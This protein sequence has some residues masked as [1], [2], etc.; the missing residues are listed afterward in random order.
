[1]SREPQN[2]SHE[3][4][5]HRTVV[6]DNRNGGTATA[7]VAITEYQGLKMKMD[8]TRSPPISGQRRKKGGSGIGVFGKH[9]DDK[10]EAVI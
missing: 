3:N 7:I 1:M 4:H 8:P 6:S 2:G 9:Q 10:M 5:S